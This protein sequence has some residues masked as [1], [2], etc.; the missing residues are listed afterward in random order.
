MSIFQDEQHNPNEE[1][2]TIAIGSHVIRCLDGVR[3]VLID[4]AEIRFSSA[5]YRLLLPLLEGRP[6]SDDELISKLFPSHTDTGIDDDF[7]G[8]E[9]I[10]RHMDRIRRKFRQ[11]QVRMAIR[12]ISTFGYILIP[13]PFARR[14]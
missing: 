3:A 13:H 7:W 14:R 1:L 4:K 12:R 10:D 8:R 6:V 11:H 9:T 2:R 5:E